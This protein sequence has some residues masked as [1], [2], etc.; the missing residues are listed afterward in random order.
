M[1]TFDQ[2]KV[3]DP[4]FFQENRL[5]A[6]SACTWYRN[7]E[8]LDRKQSSLKMSLNGSWKFAYA[9]NYA[10]SLQNFYQEDVDC[11]TWD[12]IRVPAHIQMEGYDLPQYVNL[13]YPWD[14]HEAVEP[15][16]IPVQFNPV[17]NYVK[18]FEIPDSMTGRKIII[19]FQGVE[20]GMALWLNGKY[21]GYSEDSFTPSEFDLTPFLIEGRN[22]LAV[23]VFKW[24]AGS[25]CED[26][27]FF[28]FSGIF[29]EV[30]LY[31]VPEQHLKDFRIQAIPDT[32]FKKGNIVFHA[33]IIGTGKI[34]L[35]CKQG[36]YALSEM[37]R[38]CGDE[39]NLHMQI[40]MPKLWSA[41]MPNLYT[42]LIYLYDEQ[43]RL[44]EVTQ[45]KIGF[46][47]F[48][49]TRN[50]MTLNGE[51]IVFKGV[52]RHEFSSVSGRAVSREELLKD[53]YTMKRNNINAIRTC[54]YPNQNEF[55]ELCDELGFYIIDET[56]LESHGCWGDIVW[57]NKD[58]SKIVPGDRPE[59]HDLVLDRAN[60]MYERDKNHTCILIWS[61]GNE[62]YGGKNIYDMSELFRQKDPGRLVQYEG[63]FHD[64][65][66]PKT[67]DVES[68]MYT[69]VENIKAFLT[70][71]NEKPFI[72]CEY[73]HA[74]GNSC[75]AMHKY[76]DLTETNP[77][78]QGGFIWD[79]IDQCLYKKDR[80]GET[81]L[82]YGGD[83]H[84]R[85][86]DY[87]FSG[88]GIVYG[89]SREESPKMQ[90]VKYNYQNIKITVMDTSFLVE[91]YNL[92]MN[93]DQYQ[94][95]A[96]LACVG[97][98]IEE[99]E[100]DTAV[101]PGEKMS[102]DLPFTWQNLQEHTVTI[103][104]R[105]REKTDWA[106]AHYEVAF[107]QKVFMRKDT[108]PF[109][110]CELMG[111]GNFEVIRGN[112]NIGVK[113]EGFEVLFSYDKG[114]VSYRYAGVELLEKIPAPD[115]WRAPIEN[116]RGNRM[117]ERYGQWKLASMY[118]RIDSG[119]TKIE[120]DQKD[121]FNVTYQ[122]QMPT[123]PATACEL[124]YRVYGDGTVQVCMNYEPV[125]DMITPPLFGVTLKMDADYDHLTWYGNGPMET[126]SD[127][128]KGAKLGLYSNL[129]K[130]NMAEYLVPQECGNKTQVRYAKVMNMQRR[131][132][133]FAGRNIDFCAIPYTSHELENADHAIEL[134]KSH[135]T[136]VRVAS[137]QMG[138]GGD[139]S[140]GARPHEEY[141][142]P[143]NEALH[144]EFFMKGI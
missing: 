31:A 87:S 134:P 113:G 30:F 115:F 116:D 91:N 101:A 67:S 11:T 114:L 14:G 112:Y 83:F 23:S 76:T 92:F 80:Y 143:S 19:S 79:Y 94:C 66:Y 54:H 124:S 34:R 35:V 108:K 4:E 84:D 85:P 61:C 90:E 137:G 144:L 45:Q 64:R 133:L 97:R 41:E 27:D 39:V 33:D 65:R 135:Y 122:Y 88:D 140:W 81:Y 49:L 6:H 16:E 32:D 72:C 106:D 40:D 74:M 17:A 75:G 136:V 105:L 128:C 127:R 63:I 68:Q 21:I 12:D 119:K 57:N 47:R 100:I 98:I 28:R 118:G 38:F 93:T 69:S 8:E 71:H 53:L 58:K 86:S 117:M 51:R 138:V 42:L 59:W 13:Q 132:L 70:E 62:S 26:Q 111:K 37:E 120:A 126:Y 73:S 104:F 20:S 107:G 130:D 139:D 50:I 52:N 78:Y 46:R 29:R 109:A 25:W 43:D 123:I 142:L 60:S 55:Y 125:Q 18:Y 89:G 102:F 15:G 141:L 129:V 131:G 36:S 95:V 10:C 2:R 48:E 3:S 22:K 9:K 1:S 44:I 24:T 56:N 7:E 99:R 96:I 5:P 103:S 110:D 77:L 121:S 82:G